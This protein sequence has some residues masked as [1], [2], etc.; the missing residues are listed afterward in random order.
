MCYWL[1]ACV[2]VCVCIGLC[3]ISSLCRAVNDGEWV[4]VPPLK[5]ATQ[6]GLVITP[7][8]QQTPYAQHLDCKQA[9][10]SIRSKKVEEGV[11][12]KGGRLRGGGHVATSF[13]RD[14][15]LSKEGLIKVKWI[16]T[17]RSWPVSQNASQASYSYIGRVTPTSHSIYK[18]YGYVTQPK[19]TL[20]SPHSTLLI[21]AAELD[22]PEGEKKVFIHLD[23]VIVNRS[24]VLWETGSLVQKRGGMPSGKIDVGLLFRLIPLYSR[25][26][27]EPVTT[28]MWSGMSRLRP[29][30]DSPVTFSRQ[31]RAGLVIG[32][33]DSTLLMLSFLLFFPSSSSSSSAS[34][35]A[36]SVCS[37]E[38]CLALS[39]GVESTHFSLC[40]LF[41]PPVRPNK[42]Q[43]G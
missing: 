39:A 29:P 19:V 10:P 11:I 6:N 25:G 1:V 16:L 26:P 31:M 37:A 38:D 15:N 18:I 23:T 34:S 17:T 13:P 8:Q 9:H 12:L 14:F 42:K 2:C 40:S 24:G 20:S 28:G 36:F 30:P 5:A 43:F 35:S 41:P 7:T 22:F 3:V 4:S 32:L 21:L 27:F 33:W